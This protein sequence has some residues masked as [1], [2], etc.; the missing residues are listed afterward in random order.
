MKKKSIKLTEKECD[1]ILFIK[2]NKS[3][4]LKNIQEYVWNYSSDLE[5]HTVET[6][7]YRIRKKFL[8]NFNEDSFL[9]FDNKNYF[10][11]IS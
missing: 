5:T 4:T 6:H 8:N 3:V 10:L 1:L 2:T 9:K 7:I 11:N